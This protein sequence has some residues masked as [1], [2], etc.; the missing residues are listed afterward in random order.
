MSV[1]KED[2]VNPKNKDSD[3][4]NKKFDTFLSMSSN[5]SIGENQNKSNQTTYNANM[6][7]KEKSFPL[8][9]TKSDY[10]T[11]IRIGINEMND[12]QTEKQL[13]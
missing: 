6:Y 10:S 5:F 13:K 3:I 8:G 9:I 2:F 12:F 7:Q 4:I 1:T 11:T